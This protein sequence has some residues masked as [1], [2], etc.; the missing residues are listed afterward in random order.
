VAVTPSTS[1]PAPGRDTTGDPIFNSPWSYA[2]V[3]TVTIPCGLTGGNLP[4]GLQLIGRGDDDWRV[5]AAAAWCERQLA[6]AGVPPLLE[7][8]P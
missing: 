1:T 4:C 5:L 6:F 8:A 2:G 7:V 3:P